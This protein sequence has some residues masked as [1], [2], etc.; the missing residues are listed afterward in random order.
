MEM[1]TSRRRR[2]NSGAYSSGL[3]EAPGAAPPAEGTT[4]PRG[5]KDGV[6]VQPGTGAAP[7]LRPVW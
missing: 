2:T 5:S 1:N 3:S 7:R 6:L 4:L